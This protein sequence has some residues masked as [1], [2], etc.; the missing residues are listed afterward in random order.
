[1]SSSSSEPYEAE[2]QLMCL[3]CYFIG[4]RSKT[5]KRKNT[6]GF[7]RAMLTECHI[8]MSYSDG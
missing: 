3:K 6:R 5:L 2:R 1:M 8:F 4:F 7:I